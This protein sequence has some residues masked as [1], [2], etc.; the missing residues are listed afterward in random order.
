MNQEIKAQWLTALRSGDYEQGYGHLN[1]KSLGGVPHFC[2][3]GV[4]CDLAVKAGVVESYEEGAWTLYGESGE[5]GGLP[6][7]VQKWAG[8]KVDGQLPVAAPAMTHEM[9]ETSSLVYFNDA[10]NYTFTQIADLIEEHH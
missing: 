6:P 5:G 9:G 3:L 8:L 10:E 2:C 1:V 7:E 4:L